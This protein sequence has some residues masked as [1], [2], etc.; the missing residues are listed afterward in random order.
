MGKRV[1]VLL[2][3]CGVK[4]G[5]EIHEATIALLELARQGAQAVCV[6]P[7]IP[8]AEVINHCFGT[9]IAGE[10]RRVL[11]ESARIAR[12]QIGALA[13]LSADSVDALVMPGGLGA[14]KNLCDFGARGA[15]CAVNPDV[16][17]IIRQLHD[18]GKPI[19]AICIAPVIVARVLGPVKQAHLRPRLTVGAPC[20]A[21]RAIDAMGGQHVV[22]AVDDAVTDEGNRLVST[23]AYMLAKSIAELEPGIGKLVR[24]VL[25]L[26]AMPKA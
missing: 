8:Q 11:V 7:D 17:R 14:V 25:R 19:G 13:E 24:E 23:P 10:A 15:E 2:S 4:D 12:G 26:A 22:C 16:A 1:A 6:A 5:S 21:S 9:P 20:D 18:G 3:G